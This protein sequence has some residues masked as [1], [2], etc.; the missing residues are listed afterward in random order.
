MAEQ[1]ALDYETVCRQLGLSIKHAKGALGQVVDFLCL[2]IDFLRMEAR[3]PARKITEALEWVNKLLGKRSCTL[4][5]IQELAGLLNFASKVIP[6][7]RTF[8]RRLYD[9]ELNF[10]RGKH[11]RRRIPAPMRADLRWWA[12]ILPKHT[13]VRVIQKQR[14]QRFIWSDAAGTKGIGGFM[15]PPGIIPP[16]EPPLT[17]DML[18]LVWPEHCFAGNVQPRYK[19]AHIN[20]KEMLAIRFALKKWSAELSNCS[21][22]I[23]CDN[24]AVV[25]GI[26]QKT[27]RGELMTVL[28]R[29][30][31]VA[32]QFDIELMIKW[33]PSEE[34]A[35]ADALSRFDMV[36]IAKLAPQLGLYR[37]SFI[38]G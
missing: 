35:L 24:S 7:G 9:A 28:R 26:R 38:N 30:L 25:G 18:A 3:L 36:R 5:E 22:L 2:E 14:Q 34:N 31:L 21:L 17:A 33:I 16:M 23:H 1:F 8:C 29:T 27:S 13:G 32:A 4:L 6:L 10:P 15:L 19:D 37:R 12:E 20:V 11:T